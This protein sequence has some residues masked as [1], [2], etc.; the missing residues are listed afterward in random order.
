MNFGGIRVLIDGRSDIAEKNP[1]P[2]RTILNFHVGDARATAAHLNELG[3]SWLV[4]VEERGTWRPWSRVDSFAASGREARVWVLDAEAG[5]AATAPVRIHPAP[6]TGSNRVFRSTSPPDALQRNATN[7]GPG[8]SAAPT[9]SPD[10]LMAIACDV[11]NVPV[12]GPNK[13]IE[14]VVSLGVEGVHTKPRWPAVE[15]LV[16]TTTPVTPIS[17]ARLVSSSVPRFVIVPL[18]PLGLSGSHRKARNLLP[19]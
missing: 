2:G 6:L 12:N 13:D 18:A 8:P 17:L 16:P 4:E 7:P 11:T 3:V 1:E 5:T 19:G 14:P 9:M 10:T 15:V